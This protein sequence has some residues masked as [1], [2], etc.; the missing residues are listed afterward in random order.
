MRRLI[1]QLKSVVLALFLWHTIVPTR[2]M[3]FPLYNAGDC[4]LIDST[5]QCPFDLSLPPKFMYTSDRPT[6]ETCNKTSC[7]MYVHICMCKFMYQYIECMYSTWLSRTYLLHVHVHVHV[8]TECRCATRLFTC[9]TWCTTRTHTCLF[10]NV[11]LDELAFASEEHCKNK[12]C[13]LLARKKIDA[14]PT[15]LSLPH[16]TTTIQ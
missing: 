10:V 7:I 6:T 12:I 15:D 3:Q 4:I 2:I 16:H 5:A 9:R 8:E 11:A 1:L 13:T 14:P